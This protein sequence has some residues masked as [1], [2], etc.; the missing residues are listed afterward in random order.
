MGSPD[1]ALAPAF[2]DELDEANRRRLRVMLPLMVVVH[3]IHVAMFRTTAAERA[4]LDPV[5]VRWRDGVTEVHEVWFVVAVVLT[6]A[7]FRVK[8]AA[9]RVLAPLTAAAYLAHGVVVVGIDQLTL[10]SV[11]PFIGY[12][13]GTAVVLCFPPRV[14]VILYS[15]AAAA[16]VAVM[17]VMQPS[18]SARLGSMPNG[19]SIVVVSVA[20]AW[21]LY[22]GRRRDFVQRATIERL[23]ASLERRVA[24]Q[25]SEIVARAD[26]VA[27]LN[28]Q[29]QVQV[30]E[31]SAELSTALAKLALQAEDGESVRTGTILGDRFEVGDILGTGGMGAVYAGTD[32][33]TGLRVAIKVTQAGSSQQLDG[34][35]R[36]LREA[37]SAARVTHPAV[38]RTL[39]VDVSNDGMLYQ[40][41]ELVEGE[42]LQSRCVTRQPW[43]PGTV[44]RLVSVLCDALAAAHAEGVVHRDVKPANI[45]LTRTS[46]GLKLLDFGIAKLHEDARADDRQTTQTGAMLGTP[47]YMAPEQFDTRRGVTDRVDVYAVGVLLFLLL[48]GHHPFEGPTPRAMMADHLLTDAPDVRSAAPSVPDALADLVA[49]CL[50]K[51]A[52]ERPTASSLAKDLAAFADGRDV[53]SLDA[54]EKARMLRV[55]GPPR[56]EP[57]PTV[58]E[59]VG[60]VT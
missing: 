42:T 47:A 52:D 16:F 27:T 40:V 37:Q 20:V 7:V 1:S 22:L 44:A 14:T 9:A 15:A 24:E 19:G 4:A 51:S 57:P 39:H 48:T 3:A 17:L 12:C 60:R 30:R 8:G 45:M 33:V 25:V 56:E 46:P 38:V 41:Q 32:R 28:A 11:T 2:R 55:A 35:R 26:E 49:R 5:V 31:R 10:T 36:F 59:G 34:L 29:L 50:R 54:L 53:P 21:M 23:N 6:V 13:L 43:E 58:A 18:A